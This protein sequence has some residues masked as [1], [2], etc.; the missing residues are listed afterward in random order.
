MF[1]YSIISNVT[2]V[3]PWEDMF[4]RFYFFP[5]GLTFC[6]NVVFFPQSL[7]AFSLYL[8]NIMLQLIGFTLPEQWVPQLM[9]HSHLSPSPAA[10]TAMPCHPNHSNTSH[11]QQSP[12]YRATPNCI[13]WNCEIQE[14][15]VVFC[16][17]VIR[18]G[19]RVHPKQDWSKQ[20]TIQTRTGD[21]TAT[22]TEGIVMGIGGPV[23]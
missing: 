12:S 2:V 18:R 4:W 1:S 22:C 19:L 23:C 3:L 21:G 7:Q 16:T 5:Q 20:C 10:S 9:L 14:L 11:A 17:W 15:H 8:L 6:P 13:M